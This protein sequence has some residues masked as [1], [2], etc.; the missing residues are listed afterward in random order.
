MIFIYHQKLGDLWCAAAMEDDRILAT[1]WTSNEQTV[2]KQMLE[3]MPCN[4][5]FQVADKT[6]PVAEKVLTTIKLMIEGKN[7]STDFKYEMTHL[8]KYSQRVLSFL[9]QVPVGYVTTYGALAKAAGGGPRAVGGVMRRN[10][11]SPLIPCHRVVRSDFTIGGFGGEIV[12][13]GVRTKLTLLQREDRGY[14]EATKLEVKDSVLQLFPA[15]F[16]RKN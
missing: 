10:P 4:V 1:G 11:F 16:A 13:E 15:S 14:K 5:Q 6:T 9:A 3:S 8:P 2:L 7:V 12:G